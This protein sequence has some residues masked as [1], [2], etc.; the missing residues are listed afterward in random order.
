VIGDLS[1]SDIRKPLL[2]QIWTWQPDLSV[3]D[4]MS[5][6]RRIFRVDLDQLWFRCSWESEF[7]AGVEPRDSKIPLVSAFVRSERINGIG[8][9]TIFFTNG[10][11]KDLVGWPNF[12]KTTS[13]NRNPF[14][15]PKVTHDG[16]SQGFLGELVSFDRGPI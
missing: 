4:L 2:F 12:R 14:L 10:V 6:A 11:K 15:C 13:F 16:N 3:I 8:N 9:L 1:I 7:K 5:K